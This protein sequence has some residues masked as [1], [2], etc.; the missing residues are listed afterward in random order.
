[1]KK[2]TQLC[3]VYRSASHRSRT[4]TGFRAQIEILYSQTILPR[5]SHM[6]QISYLYLTHL[7]FSIC[8]KTNIHSYWM[9]WRMSWS[10]VDLSQPDHPLSTP[11]NRKIHISPWYT[12]FMIFLSF[13]HTENSPF[14]NIT[15]WL[16]QRTYIAYIYV[17]SLRSRAIT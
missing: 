17:F 6:P 15:G 5:V 10:P 7:L 3:G 1:M 2:K 16:S 4:V 14:I 12:T 8:N 13:S 11:K 9:D